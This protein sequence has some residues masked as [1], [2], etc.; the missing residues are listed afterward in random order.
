ME[1]KN[2]NLTE[3]ITYDGKEISTGRVKILNE[4][5]PLQESDFEKLI[6]PGLGFNDW[7]RRFI[8]ISLGAI[9]IFISKISNFLYNFGS[10]K[11]KNEAILDIKDY[12]WIA[13]LISLGLSVL[14]FVFGCIFKNKRDRII[15]HIKN[16]YKSA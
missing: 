13:I 4:A 7:S 2:Q 16:F 3:S 9:V 15:E 8:L 11:D 12:E 10:H 14:L 1:V 6:S 5:Y